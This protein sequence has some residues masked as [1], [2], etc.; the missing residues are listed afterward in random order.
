MLEAGTPPTKMGALARMHRLAMANACKPPGKG[1]GDQHCSGRARPAKNQSVRARRVTQRIVA[2]RT[3][4]QRHF[5]A[6]HVLVT[7]RPVNAR[8]PR[9]SRRIRLLAQEKKRVLRRRLTRPPT[10]M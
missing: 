3:L 7:R 4:S 9:S 2:T 1:G 8:C 10:G 6:K 5:P